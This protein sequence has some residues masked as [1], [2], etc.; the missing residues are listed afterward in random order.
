MDEQQHEQ[1]RRTAA[2]LT[3]VVRALDDLVDEIETTAG[4]L[5]ELQD[6]DRDAT[7]GRTLARTAA[8]TCGACSALMLDDEACPVCGAAQAQ[9]PAR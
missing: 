7:R 5:E 9:E 3:R 1:I 2:R 8:V 4:A 6:R